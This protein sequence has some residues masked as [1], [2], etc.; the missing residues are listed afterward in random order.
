MDLSEMIGRFVARPLD[1]DPDLFEYAGLTIVLVTVAVL[2][3]RVLK[4][5]V[6]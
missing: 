6:E 5:I 3:T 4:N 1:D 2:W